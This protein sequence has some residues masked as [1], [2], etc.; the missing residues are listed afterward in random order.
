MARNAGTGAV[1]LELGRESEH[2]GSHKLMPG[3][4]WQDIVPGVRLGTLDMEL[5]QDLETRSE[6]ADESMEFSFVLSGSAQV[7]V[8]SGR[9]VSSVDVRPNLAISHYAPGSKVSFTMRGKQTV[10]MLGVALDIA[11]LESMLEQDEFRSVERALAA[12]E[13]MLNRQSVMTPLQKMVVNQMFTCMLPSAARTLFMQGKALELLAYQ[14]STMSE[15]A[16]ER[17]FHG[18]VCLNSEDSE[19]IRFARETLRK[20]MT[21]PPSLP[22][23]GSIAGIAVNKLTKGFRAMYGKSAYDCL[24][25]DRMGRAQVLLQERRLNVSEVAWE[26]GYINVSHFSRAFQ[27]HFGIRPKAY[28]REMGK[29]F[30]TVP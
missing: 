7:V 29:R 15:V 21:D 16:D 4:S 26:V 17:P 30:H 6:R 8:R 18:S 10:K 20:R 9:S 22:Q 24:R 3:L 2:T 19:R 11:F 23:L 13:E 14:L 25:E 5:K 1:V 28:Q 12:P 27:K